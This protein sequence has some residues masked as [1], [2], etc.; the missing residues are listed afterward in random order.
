MLYI[1]RH[2]NEGGILTESFWAL[3]V[4]SEE[5][6]ELVRV[7]DNVFWESDDDPSKFCP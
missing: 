6:Q 3:D 1:L 7:S 4:W 2:P 5:V